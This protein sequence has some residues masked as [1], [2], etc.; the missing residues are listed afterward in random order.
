M[1][2]LLWLGPPGVLPLRTCSHS[3]SSSSS[4][5]AQVFLLQHCFPLHFLL[6]VSALWLLVFA[7]LSSLGD[8]VL[9]SLWD[10]RRVD[11]SVCSA[12]LVVLE[13]AVMWKQSGSSPSLPLYYLCKSDKVKKANNT[14][15][16]LWK[17]FDLTD[18][19]GHQKSRHLQ[20]VPWEPLMNPIQC[21]C[22]EVF[23]LKLRLLLP[24]RLIGKDPDAGK[25]WRQ[26]DKGMTEDEM[27]GWPHRLNGHGH[28]F[29]Q[30]LAVAD[31]QGSLACCSPWVSKNR[32]QL[33]NWT[34]HEE[35]S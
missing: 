25:D 21:S 29:E 20:T 9:T 10:P 30:A 11:I 2:L 32:I 18:L 22:I 13:W 7:C 33:S 12:F 31:G 24:W 3:A 34:E 14:L 5:T 27:V 17:N 26:E 28:E 16:L 8:C 1:K 6:W 19:K 23:R 4:I 35:R 15:V